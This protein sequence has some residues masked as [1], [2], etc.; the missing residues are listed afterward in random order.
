M[1]IRYVIGVV[2]EPPLGRLHVSIQPGWRKPD[3]APIYVLEL[4][5][6]GAPTG[7]GMEGA[8]SFFDVGHDWIVRGFR[9]LT[10]SDMHKI[11][12]LTNG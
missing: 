12:R 2:G 11:W 10:T 8:Q 6:R 4:T 1:Q 9:D 3:N 7:I 5:A